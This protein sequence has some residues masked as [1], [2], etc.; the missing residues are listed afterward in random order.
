MSLQGGSIASSLED[1]VELVG[2]VLCLL[3]Q[4]GSGQLSQAPHSSAASGP[5]HSPREQ[6]EGSSV[7]KQFIGAP[8]LG[9]YGG[10]RLWLLEM[11]MHLKERRQD[12]C[13]RGYATCCRGYTGMLL[14]L[15]G[16]ETNSERSILQQ[17]YLEEPLEK[18]GRWYVG[19]PI[20]IMSAC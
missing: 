17:A 2:P 13:H 9:V 15:Y 14:R 4:P 6:E 18:W 7:S 16:V 8:G 3:I 5:Q 20:R 19:G 12:I 11:S 10:T 1:Q